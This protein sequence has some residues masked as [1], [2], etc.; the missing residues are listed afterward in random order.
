MRRRLR[1]CFSCMLVYVC[2]F[3]LSRP[4][5][6]RRVRLFICVWISRM[7]CATL[8]FGR[9]DVMTFRSVCS[10]LGAQFRS[11]FFDGVNVV[12]LCDFP[13]MLFMWVKIV[14]WTV[15]A[16]A[17]N[18]PISFRYSLGVWVS[19]RMPLF[20]CEWSFLCVVYICCCVCYVPD[21]VVCMQRGASMF[22]W[23]SCL[24][25]LWTRFVYHEFAFD[26]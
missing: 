8:I 16:F 13:Y 4:Y 26:K 20:S 24:F 1:T 6:L 9:A 19:A 15:G 22:S 5:L 11:W 12:W 23:N 10:V 14:S 2:G 18:I 21:F 7:V 17:K 3:R 25:P